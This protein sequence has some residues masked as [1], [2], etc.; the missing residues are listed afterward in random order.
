[1]TKQEIIALIESEARAAG[2]D[3][4]CM[5]RIAQI[6]SGLNPQSRNPKSGAAGLYQIMPFHN[7]A[8]VLDPLTNIRWAMR[9]TK[10][11]HDYLRKNGVPVDCFWTYL[12]HQ[13][14]AGGA[15]ILWNKRNLRIDQLTEKERR[16]LLANVG[17]NDFTTVAQF[18]QFW[19]RKVTNNIVGRAVASLP[20]TLQIS[21]ARATDY[22]LTAILVAGLGV[23]ASAC[24]TKF[25]ER[26]PLWSKA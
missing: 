26:K 21:L 8:N 12:A 2:L 13:Q 18:L 3:P 4:A 22:Q 6:E 23:V 24:I 5:V 16:N 17:A 15:L 9:F 1:M 7:V 20:D 14:G 10:Q 11:N 19:E 25:V